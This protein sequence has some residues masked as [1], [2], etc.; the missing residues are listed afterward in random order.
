MKIHLYKKHNNYH[1]V[2]RADWTTEGNFYFHNE[3][4]LQ[5]M[6]QSMQHASVISF[7]FFRGSLSRCRCTT[8]LRWT[9]T[10]S[11]ALSCCFF[12]LDHINLHVPSTLQVFVLPLSAAVSSVSYSG[13]SLWFIYIPGNHL[14]LP[15]AGMQQCWCFPS[16]GPCSGADRCRA[17]RGVGG[18]V[19]GRDWLLPITEAVYSAFKVCFQEQHAECLAP[20]RPIPNREV[21]QGHTFCISVS[22]AGGSLSDERLFRPSLVLT[23]HSDNQQS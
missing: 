15:V 8:E 17:G 11:P 23:D 9:W 5:H 2:L 13:R 12:L 20:L 19:A 4:F 10:S 16:L 7:G 21:S 6:Q 18:T 22:P 3:K 14:L 1:T